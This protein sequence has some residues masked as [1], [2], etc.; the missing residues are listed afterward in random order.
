MTT[1]LAAQ[2]AEARAKGEALIRDDGQGC[3]A[4][5]GGEPRRGKNAKTR[6]CPSN[7]GRS[8]WRTS[9]PTSAR[10]DRIAARG[11]RPQTSLRCRHCSEAL[12]G[13]RVGANIVRL[14]KEN[15]LEFEPWYP[16]DER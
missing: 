15:T 13:R 6:S 3:S 5:G 14:R 9:P 7:I 1:I 11:G 2:A 8:F 12:R 4:K 16:G 10:P